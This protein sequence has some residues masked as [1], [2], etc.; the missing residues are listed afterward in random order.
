MVINGLDFAVMKS[1]I[2]FMYCGE[3]SFSEDHLKHFIAAVKFFKIVALENVFAE[4]EY[5][6]VAGMYLTAF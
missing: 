3:C 6:N 2:E 5:Q 4:N 1:L